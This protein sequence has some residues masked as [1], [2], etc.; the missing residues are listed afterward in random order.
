M[1]NRTAQA[2][3]MI[4]HCTLPRR[5]AGAIAC[6]ASIAHALPAAAQPA[7]AAGRYH[8]LGLSSDGRVLWWGTEFGHEKRVPPAYPRQVEGLP[9][10]IAIAAGWEHSSA[11]TRDGSVYEWGYSPYRMRQVY[12]LQPMLGPCVVGAILSGGH[13]KDPCGPA[14]RAR[15][16]RMHVERP[17]RIPGLPPAVAVAAAD[18]HSAIVTRD[19]EVYCWGAN[20]FPT[21]IRGLE[22]IKAIALGQFHGVALRDDG[23]VLGWGG[24]SGGA[25]AYQPERSARLCENPGPTPFFIGA[26]AIAAYADSTYALR[27]DGSVWAWGSSW[28]G[29]PALPK[30]VNPDNK[31][32]AF[33]ARRIATL[34]GATTLGGGGAP[35]ALTRQGL[36]V[37]WFRALFPKPGARQQPST[38]NIAAL[39][40]YSS[41][42]ALRPDGFVCTMGDNMYGA[43]DPG[44]KA[45]EVERFMPV[46][47][48]DGRGLLNLADAGRAAPPDL[49]ASQDTAAAGP[50]QSNPPT[51]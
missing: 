34:D 9:P 48:G 33:V 25:I 8:N 40:S 20:A 24:A 23:V 16:A 7:V 22:R 47:L 6:M 49:C 17:M 32:D 3:L 39:S 2:F 43:T 21:K 45:M 44:D 38:A 26:I 31:P 5:L 30:D 18:S 11:I 1:A 14:E 27:A 35:S 36:A 13:G 29:N 12:L 28:N 15:K 19:G 10:A 50:G 37:T 4:P 46:A 42:L 41:I 51:P